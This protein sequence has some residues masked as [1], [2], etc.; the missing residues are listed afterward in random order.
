MAI[1]AVLP[2]MRRNR[3]GRIVN[4]SS[5]VAADGYPG[6]A[7][8]GAAKAALHD[9][10]RTLTRELAPED[11][12][13]NVVIARFGADRGGAQLDAAA[14]GTG[15]QSLVDTPCPHPRRSRLSDC[16]RRLGRQHHGQ[17]RSNPHQRRHAPLN[18]RA[19]R[20]ANSTLCGIGVVRKL[21]LCPTTGWK[22][23]SISHSLISSDSWERPD[24]FQSLW[25]L[26][27]V[28]SVATEFVLLRPK[29]NHRGR[30]VDT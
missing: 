3:W 9:L 17:R 8:Y 25:V 30:S 7:T 27:S 11:I 20:R 28:C 5:A 14:G 4:V 10:T 19:R 22:S 29:R 12:L 13:T 2:Y 24:F 15:H 26:A 6:G 16:I 1:M 18:A 21:N 23:S